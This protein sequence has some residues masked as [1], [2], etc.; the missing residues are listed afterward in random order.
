MADVEKSAVFKVEVD[1]GDLEKNQQAIKQRI[2]EI[3]NEQLQLDAS[4]KE[5]QKTFKENNSTLRTLEQQLKLNQKALNDLTSAEKASTDRTNFANNSIKQNREL[6]KELNAEYIRIQNPTKEQTANLKNLTDTLKQQE[7]AIGDNRRNVGNY[8]ESLKGAL[9]D[10]LKSAL[11]GIKG[12]NAGL[13]ASPI[14]LITQGIQLLAGAF[15]GLEPVVDFVEQKVALL[16]AGLKAFVGGIFGFV[17]ALFSGSSATE[18]YSENIEGLGSEIAN[19]ALEA[20]RLTKAIQDLEDA[21]SEALVTTAR[22]NAEISKLLISAKD[23]TKSEQERL[24]LLSRA[25]QIEQENFRNEVS[26]ALKR[27]AIAQKELAQA[28]RAGEDRGEALRKANEATAQRIALEG[29]SAELQERIQVRRNQLIESEETAREQARTKRQAQIEKEK[30]EEEKRLAEQIKRAEELKKAFEDT[31]NA[32]F[33][34]TKSATEIFFAEQD[35]RLREQLANRQITL[36]EFNA[37]VEE[38]NRLRLETELQTLIDYS[39]NVEGLEDDIAKKR[40]ELANL[41]TSKAIEGIKKE[42]AERKQQAEKEKQT[43]KARQQNLDAFTEQVTARAVNA[44]FQQGDALKNFQRVLANTLLDILERQLTAQIVGQSL[45]QPD[46]IATFGATGITRSAILLGILK[47]S[48]AVARNFLSGFA[49]GGLVE[50]F[51]NGGLS[52]KRIGSGDGIPIRRSNGDNLL[53]TIKTGEVIL[54]ERQQRAIGG[55]AVFRKIGV[56]GFAEGGFAEDSFGV[57][58]LRTPTPVDSGLQPIVD[59][60]RNLRIY[61]SVTE[62]REVSN[63]LNIQAEIAEL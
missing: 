5:N 23:R 41:S 13:T 35:A 44:L 20:E 63:E 1:F 16:T 34:F 43:L 19:T 2:N 55:P 14:G 52:G 40:I 54:N 42:E 26:L 30:Q 45:A 25:G 6:L 4:S 22:N 59:A 10:G 60:I 31:T 57:Q 48:F 49:E 27:E 29:Q 56:P 39:A 9:S 12:L 28:I 51:A 36:D 47:G 8:A 24:A 46:S 50:A 38:N 7:S 61:T 3:R 33:E 18:A 58:S 11:G 15:G 37:Q 17:G 32:E 53:A 62:I 21:E